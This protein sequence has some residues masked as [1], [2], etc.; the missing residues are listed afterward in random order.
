M[1]GRTRLKAILGGGEE[2]IVSGLR[3]ALRRGGFRWLKISYPH[4]IGH[5]VLE[6]DSFLRDRMVSGAAPRRH[7]LLEPDN[8]FANPVVA[9]YLSRY[10][11]VVRRS[12]WSRLLRR[13]LES[14][15]LIEDTAPYA[16]A[17][18]ETARCF[19]V[20]DRWG[21]RPPLF[22]LTGSDVAHR[23][24]ALAKLGL[25]AGAWFVCVHARGGGYSPSDEF[26]HSYRNVPIGDYGPAM[27]RIV[28]RG[29]WCIRMGD[30]TMEP[31]PPKRN[32]IDYALSPLRSARLDVILPASCR[33]FLS[34][35]SGLYNV[36]AMFGRPSALANTAPLAA[37]YS[38]GVGDLS[39]PQ[40]L[41]DAGGRAMSFDEI[42]ASG[43]ADLRITPEFVAR[44][45]VPTNVTPDEIA[46]LASE[47]LDR[48]DGRAEYTPAD[49]ERQARFRTQF[50]EGHYSFGAGSRIGRDYLRA[51]MAE[52]VGSLAAAAGPVE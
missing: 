48:L 1:T 28:E 36:A 9:E 37:S 42:F 23:A 7:V 11:T 41:R 29:G 32:C 12:R 30:P 43:A 15:G 44:G 6:A 33:F 40:R 31:M 5:L 10:F 19:A 26:A 47:M 46:D 3:L 51:H 4:R 20:Y 34:C 45:L 52:Q 18:Y 49:E 21:A 38:Q 14:E 16:V 13:A 22:E 17:M 25:P 27:D 39:I 24:K 50:R 8:G 2:A 35:S